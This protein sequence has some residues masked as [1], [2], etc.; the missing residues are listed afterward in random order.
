MATY[1]VV[2]DSKPIRLALVH[3]LR[4]YSN[5][6]EILEAAS[7][8][9]AVKLFW[10]KPIDVVFLDMM[11]GA[12]DALGPMTAML[13]ARPAA[14]IVLVT[15]LHRE[16]PRVVEAISGGAFAHVR[17]PVRVDDVR[18]VLNQ[19]EGETGSIKRIR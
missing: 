15:G 11:L 14:R 13:E 17:K 9:E 16:D 6:A 2:D 10:E 1:L 19:I 4:Q 3:A 8:E 18:A 5:S 12:T 7:G